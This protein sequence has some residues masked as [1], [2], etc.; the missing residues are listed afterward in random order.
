MHSKS[1]S[2]ADRNGRARQASKKLLAN[3]ATAASAQAVSRNEAELAEHA[4]AIKKALGVTDDDPITRG[5]RRIRNAAATCRQCAQCGRELKADE[6]VWRQYM[7]IGPGFFG[8]TSYAIAPVCEPCRS[9]YTEFAGPRPCLNCGRPVHQ[10]LSRRFRLHCVCCSDCG[11]AVRIKAARDKRAQDR[12]PAPPCLECFE[13][14]EPTR[15]DAQFCSSACR[16][17]AYRKRKAVTG[18]VCGTPLTLGS[19][20]ADLPDAAPEVNDARKAVRS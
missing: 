11:D 10:E 2:P 7:R 14:F 17:R 9:N 5:R 1:L 19:R 4:A 8:G 12:E 20:N 6:P 18:D 13:T 3:T 15:A 16:Q